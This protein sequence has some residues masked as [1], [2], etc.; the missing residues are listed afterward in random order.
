MKMTRCR[1]QKASMNFC[2]AGIQTR[3]RADFSICGHLISGIKG[4]H[5]ADKTVYALSAVS[6]LNMPRWR[7]ITSSPGVREDRQ[8]L[9][10]VKCS[11]RPVMGKRPKNIKAITRLTVW[12][13]YDILWMSGTARTALWT[14]STGQRGRKRERSLTRHP[15]PR[16]YDGHKCIRELRMGYYVCC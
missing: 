2:F 5:T 10:T 7:A 3:L 12:C 14:G 8:Y 6:I 15:A 1:K 4:R 11:A 13:R 9:R 16:L